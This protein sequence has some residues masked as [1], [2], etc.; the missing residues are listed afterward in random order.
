ML[1][2]IHED[3]SSYD[4]TWT[5]LWGVTYSFLTLFWSHLFRYFVWDL[6]FAFTSVGS[7]ASHWFYLPL[8]IS[9]D[10][11]N[12]HSRSELLQLCRGINNSANTTILEIDGHFWGRGSDLWF[13]CWYWIDPI[14]GHC[15][16]CIRQPVLGTCCSKETREEM[17]RV[18]WDRWYCQINR[19]TGK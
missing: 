3:R 13:L 4:V 7:S 17:Q 16:W 14:K 2:F 8:P 19:N 10:T 9:T 1:I 15:V 6:N 18:I 5:R 11:Q 12:V